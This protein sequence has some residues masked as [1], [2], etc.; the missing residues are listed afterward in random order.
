[1]TGNE[2]FL[3]LSSSFANQALITKALARA[4]Y[5]KRNT[6]LLDDVFSGIDM[7][8]AQSVS[9]RLLGRDTGLLRNDNTTVVLTTHNRTSF[10]LILLFCFQILVL[11]WPG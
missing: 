4:V 2:V 10:S 11:I 9:R 3:V 1:M 8:T 6:L 5:S 7:H